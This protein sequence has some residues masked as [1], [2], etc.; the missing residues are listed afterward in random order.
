MVER[1]RTPRTFLLLALAL[2]IPWRVAIAQGARAA[3]ATGAT[4]AGIVV[5][6][7]SR[8]PLSGVIVSVEGTPVRAISDSGGRYRLADVPAGPQVI[9]A[10]RL[11]YAP[12]RVAVTVPGSGIVSRDIQMAKLALQMPEVRVSA[13]PVSR[14]R[15]ELGTATVV[16]R[17]AISNLGTPSLAGVLELIPGA[18]LQPPGLDNV[19]QISLRAV[20]TISRDAER[21]AAFGT[22]II[23][24]GVPLSNNANLQSTGPRGEI[25]PATSAGGGIDLRR[26]PAA[27]LERVEVIRGVPSARYGDLTNGAIIVDTRAGVVAPEFVV[28]YDP[29]TSEMNMAGGRRLA[30]GQNGSVTG[31]LARTAVLPGLRDA[32]VW[33]G[34]VDLAHRLLLGSRTRADEDAGSIIDSR[35]NI[36]QVYERSP[37]QPDVHPGQFSSNR[38]GGARLSQRMRFGALAGRHAE[39]TTS[40]SREWQNTEQQQLEIRGAEPFTDRLTPGRSTGFYVGGIYPA[41]VHLAGAPWELYS[42]VEGIYPG[43]ALAGMSTLKTGIELRRE[44]NAG[45]GYQF[46]LQFPPQSTFNGVNGY[47]RPHRYDAIPP[48]A[49]SAAYVDERLV[50]GLPFGI[51]LDVQ[52]GLRADALHRGQWWTSGARDLALQPRVNV[53]LA[54]R[55]W[56]RLRGAWG[57]VAKVPAVGDLYP[58]PQFYDV[59]N[60][61]WYPPDSTERLAVLTTS[62]RDPTNPD[63]GFAVGQKAEAGFE[64]DLGP[65]AAL[66]ITAFRDITDGAVGYTSEPDFLLREHFAL[67]DSSTGTGRP[68]D[69]MTPAQAIDTVPIFVDRPRNLNR[70]ENHGVELTLSLPEI[71]PIRTRIELQGAWTVSRLSNDALYFGASNRLSDFQVDSARTR[72][73]YWTGDIERGERAVATARL[74]HHQAALGLV[75]TATVQEFL[76]EQTVQEGGTDTLAWS[77]YLTRSGTLVPVPPDRRGDPEFADLRKTRL[78]L[79]TQPQSPPSDWMLNL[80]I[81]KTIFGEGRLSL[82]AFNALDRLGKPETSLRNGRL[83]PRFR[84]GLEVSAPTAALG[85]L[86]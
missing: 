9:A 47:D 61:N 42:R 17:E 1:V 80:Q 37:E 84:V 48:V 57:R 75:I 71:A 70:I 56:L 7:P 35:L 28:R 64:A 5:Q 59:V 83:F 78:G 49:T 66:G 36:Y 51:G 8:R 16:T 23:M 41:A 63:L 55:D 15:G 2:G 67:T 73:P 79:I 85:R 4:I 14:A 21:S 50:T 40:I 82:Y 44:W 86:F 45:P 46:R 43:Q 3:T 38:S 58:A 25:V 18:T 65:L 76:R 34:S 60:V 69:Y 27:A 33:R 52:A 39:I 54:P 81:A 77:G 6:M 30:T 12:A 68:P 29:R 62:V 19:Q 74:I 24:D 26:I 11:G 53:Q 22:L 31:N 10:R 13:D 20:P 72:T 32:D